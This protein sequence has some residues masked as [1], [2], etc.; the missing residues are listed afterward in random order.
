MSDKIIQFPGQAAA[1]SAAPT[2]PGEAS[3]PDGL[4]EDQRK[5]IQVVLGGMPFVLI[6][7]KS[8]DRGAD[9]F[10]AVHGD[11]TDLRNALPHLAGVIDRAYARKGI[12]QE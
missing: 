8:T 9:F 3:G 7:I 12:V 4:S 6:G 2:P 5:A 11:H 1:K 10:T